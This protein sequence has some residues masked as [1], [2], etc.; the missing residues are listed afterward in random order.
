MQF[1]RSYKFVCGLVFLLFAGSFTFGD[2]GV[3][4]MWQDTPIIGGVILA[5]TGPVC[6][7]DDRSQIAIGVS[8]VECVC[9]LGSAPSPL[10]PRGQSATPRGT[11]NSWPGAQTRSRARS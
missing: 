6:C 1:V 11:T 2:A 7:L 8:G 9:R 3:R 4:W 5:M 10:R